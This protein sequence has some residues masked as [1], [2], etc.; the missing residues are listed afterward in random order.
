MGTRTFSPEEGVYSVLKYELG[1]GATVAYMDEQKVTFRTLVLGK[2][3]TS[4]SSSS[5]TKNGS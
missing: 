2:V 3:T 4:K 1:Y 5:R